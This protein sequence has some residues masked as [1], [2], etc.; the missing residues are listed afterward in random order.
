MA[1]IHILIFQMLVR[2][3]RPQSMM[4]LASVDD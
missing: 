4:S 2:E 3:K 1:Y